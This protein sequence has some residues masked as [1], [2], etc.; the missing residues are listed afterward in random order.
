ADA[1]SAMASPHPNLK[2]RARSPH[3][4]TN[5]PASASD[6]P[7]QKELSVFS[8]KISQLSRPT[9]TGVLL[10]SKV[11]FAAD[12]CKIE[13]LKKARS[14][15]KKIPPTAITISVLGLTRGDFP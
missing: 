13:V 11:A 2:C 14:R 9:K 1:A 7:S 6:K 10:P 4:M 15:A 12:V 5:D 3:T 8:G